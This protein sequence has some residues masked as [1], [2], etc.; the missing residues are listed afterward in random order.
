MLTAVLLLGCVYEP[1]SGVGCNLWEEE[2]CHTQCLWGTVWPAHV[3]A[4]SWFLLE[5][6]SLKAYFLTET[7]T[8]MGTVE[9]AVALPNAFEWHL[10]LPECLWRSRRKFFWLS[11]MNVEDFFFSSPWHTLKLHPSSSSRENFKPQVKTFPWRL[12]ESPGA[13]LRIDLSFPWWM[14]ISKLFREGG[15]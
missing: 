14:V 12:R 9:C 11:L 1:G 15:N 7:E 3:S 6:V 5:G 2:I 10:Q 8:D 4:P 13:K